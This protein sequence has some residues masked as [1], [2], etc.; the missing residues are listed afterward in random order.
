M[1]YLLFGSLFSA[2][3]QIMQ[4]CTALG[5]FIA[6]FDLLKLILRLVKIEVIPLSQDL[7]INF[8]KKLNIIIQRSYSGYSP[9]V[10]PVITGL[11][12]GGK[13]ITSNNLF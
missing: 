7:F 12:F 2:S 6:R 11:V 1:F 10:Y 9:I 5:S 8:F 3:F 13:I 4:H